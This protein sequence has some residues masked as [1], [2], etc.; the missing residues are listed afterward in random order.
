MATKVNIE[1]L[2]T[3]ARA[4]FLGRT[5]KASLKGVYEAGDWLLKKAEELDVY[6]KPLKPLLQGRDLIE[7]GYKPSKEF[8]RLLDAVYSEQLEGKIVSRI[9]AV[10]F[11]LNIKER[12]YDKN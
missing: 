1:E 5:T 2:V 9:E 8:K 7:L 12:F 11:V 6:S 4:D 3:V 10:E